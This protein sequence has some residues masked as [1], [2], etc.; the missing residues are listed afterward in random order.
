MFIIFIMF[1]IHNIISLVCFL[2]LTQIG[3]IKYILYKNICF[4]FY[5]LHT[6]FFLLCFNL[7][8]NSYFTLLFF[9][10]Q[11]P[12]YISVDHYPFYIKKKKKHKNKKHKK[13][14]TNFSQTKPCILCMIRRMGF[15][16]VFFYVLCTLMNG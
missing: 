6:F 14:I 2:L 5:V 13:I 15:Y 12:F 7:E 16:V 10:F 3:W 9:G 11:H 1:T 4:T 8:S